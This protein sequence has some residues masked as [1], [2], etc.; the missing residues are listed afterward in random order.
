MLLFSFFFPCKHQ[1]INDL[2]KKNVAN[3]NHI[4]YFFI[5]QFKLRIKN[6]S[7]KNIK[8]FMS[9][10]LKTIDYNSRLAPSIEPQ[11]HKKPADYASGRIVIAVLPLLAMVPQVSL[12]LQGYAGINNAT[13]AY[14]NNKEQS[15]FKNKADV[16]LQV[17]SLGLLYFN[18]VA[19]SIIENT[20]G[21]Y[22]N[23]IK[24]KNH[25]TEGNFQKVVKKS[26]NIAEKSAYIGSVV[27]G[28]PT[29][30]LI[31]MVAKG[32]L[33]IAKTKKFYD[34]G[35]TL[36]ALVQAVVVVARGYGICQH[37]K[38]HYEDICDS[39]ENFKYKFIQYESG[40]YL[41]YEIYKASSVGYKIFNEDLHQVA[42]YEDGTTVITFDGK[43]QGYTE[44]GHEG[45]L[46]LTDKMERHEKYVVHTYD[47]RKIYTYDNG[48]S[49]KVDYLDNKDYTY[50]NGKWVKIG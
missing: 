20:K 26:F 17:A 5:M 18:P 45:Y 10:I 14:K 31:S 46:I 29:I 43:V 47:D 3:K 38:T 40:D 11:I 28:G 36:E 23:F 35:M 6:T 21:I 7:N 19:V 13:V 12:L 9:T 42:E 2:H 32:V 37:V 33:E 34:K 22:K 48:Q 15:S 41:S 1:I 39:I 4:Q 24:L 8:G 49:M 30:I 27:A 16:A 25:T 44:K 50:K